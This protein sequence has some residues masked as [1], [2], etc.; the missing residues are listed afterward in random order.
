MSQ[1]TTEISAILHQ[2]IREFIIEE[3]EIEPGELSDTANF[4]EA[5]D[6]DSLSLIT[7]AARIEKELHIDI[8]T[9]EWSTLT[10]L[11][12]VFAVVARHADDTPQPDD[13]PG[14]LDD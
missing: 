9:E 5:Y 3:L 1:G 8:P 10:N 11:E 14:D 2:R 6:A 7:V 13:Q 12:Q 4:V